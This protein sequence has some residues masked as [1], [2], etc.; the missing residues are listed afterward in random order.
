MIDV[1]FEAVVVDGTASFRAFASS[2]QLA[3]RH[4][5]SCDTGES[6][7]LLIGR[8]HYRSEHLGRLR[9]RLRPGDYEACRTSDAALAACL[10][11][12]GGVTGLTR[13]LG[14]YL[15]AGFDRSRRRLVVLRDPT[16]AYPCFW[17]STGPSI[18]VATTLRV[19]DEGGRHLEV[20]DEYLADY[21]AFPDDSL[22]ELPA[23]R[24][25]YRGVH[26]LLPGW[27]LEVDVAAGQVRRH[28]ACDWAQ[29]LAPCT[30]TS[31]DQA[32]DLVRAQLAASVA[33]RLSKSGRNAA[34]FSGGFDSTA[35]ALLANELLL[36]GGEPLEAL[37]LVYEHDQVQVGEGEYVA[38]ALAGCRGIHHHR[39]PAD[40]LV[41][42]AGHDRIPLVDE[43]SP[44]VADYARMDALLET[45]QRAGADTVL[46]GD[47]GDILFYRSPASMVAELLRRG[48]P[49]RALDLARASAV[50][51]SESTA[52]IL[53]RGA[54]LGLRIT[55]PRTSVLQASKWLT[56]D[57]AEGM[58][59][60]QRTRRW[61][62]QRDEG[63][64]F[65]L[66]QVPLL[67]GDW[68][69]WNLAVP[70]G[71]VQPRPFF[72]VRLMGVAAQLPADLGL[73]PA[74]IKPVLAGAMAGTLPEAILTRPT[75]AHFNSALS[76]YARHHE[77]LLEIVR[78]APPDGIVDRRALVEAVG[79]VALGAF[80]SARAANRLAMAFGYLLWVVN[81][82]RWRSRPVPYRS[83]AD[84]TGT[85]T[86][87]NGR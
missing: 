31:L 4:L 46:S 5:D 49:G 54:A 55:P 33:E 25:A 75:K 45:A 40:E 64:S 13:L 85:R 14:D 68:Y 35:V 36:P 8:L 76:G 15:V 71:L 73:V 42:F 29:R 79:R 51:R 39:C 7:F 61:E 58:N 70:R 12:E 41:D 72:D 74:P 1:G 19:M 65:S 27:C 37:T 60:T 11:R 83:L 26:R 69:H 17:T 50:R 38:A 10:Y 3:E 28:W 32:G 67:A 82:Q 62:S 63:R 2:E 56:R 84:A 21:F 20:D 22:A 23:E 59:L 66:G 57:F 6:A 16:G 81:R 24:T 44:M 18:R 9:P 87:F 43:P 77:W 52:G 80:P 48:R 78:D 53:R 86:A 34:H 30:V 47:G